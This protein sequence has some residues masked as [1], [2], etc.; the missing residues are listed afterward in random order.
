[1]TSP[2]NLEYERD[3]RFAWRWLMPG[4]ISTALTGDAELDRYLRSAGPFT[5]GAPAAAVVSAES[6]G[7]FTEM[8]L[9]QAVSC[10]AVAVYGSCRAVARLDALFRNSHA[11]VC[12][13]GLISPRAPRLV[14]PLSSPE[15]VVQAL[16]L[17]QPGSWL[18]RLGMSLLR[19]TSTANFL[20]PLKTSLLRV[21]TK[22]PLLP[23][24]MARVGLAPIPQSKYVLYLGA[25]GPERK[26]VC[27]PLVEDQ[28]LSIIKTGESPR[29]QAKLRRE[30]SQLQYLAKTDLKDQVPEL[31]D[32]YES[33]AI[34][35][36]RQSYFP[37]EPATRAAKDAGALQFLR[38]CLH[39][40]SRWSRPEDIAK[41]FTPM[42][43][44]RSAL[45]SAALAS[46]SNLKLSVGLTHGDFA[47]WNCTF[48]KSRF[49]VYDWEDGS[50]SSMH[51][52][53]AFSYSVKSRLLIKGERNSV[54]MS[55]M[56]LSFARRVHTHSVNTERH[57]RLGLALWCIA[58]DP[59]FFPDTVERIAMEMIN[60]L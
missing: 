38:A 59:G 24:P 2:M 15:T 54:R 20:R 17:H 4:A 33:K 58:Q 40:H 41:A 47:P 52:G 28:E 25:K 60:S 51:L 36:I 45:L 16:D 49:K 12:E 53:D 1:M 13:F 26:T 27:L 10:D 32:F 11:M 30:A 34:S 6:I 39:E 8:Q 31:L 3:Y 55:R 18:A 29:G 42:S 7:H 37:P 44:S 46:A 50:I 43:P 21:Y 57:F 35:I 56:A 19:A 5:P 14:V 48:S 23:W 22:S 9:S